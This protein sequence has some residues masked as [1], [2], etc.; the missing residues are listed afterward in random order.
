[1]SSSLS[2]PGPASSRCAPVAPAGARWNDLEKCASHLLRARG[3]LSQRQQAAYAT[4]IVSATARPPGTR[5][6]CSH[7]SRGW[8][9]MTIISARNAGPDDAGGAAQPGGPTPPAQPHS[10]APADREEAAIPGQP[11]VIARYPQAPPPSRPADRAPA[12]ATT[13]TAWRRSCPGWRSDDSYPGRHEK[14]P[15]SRDM[16]AQERLAAGEAAGGGVRSPPSLEPL[17]DG[18]REFPQ[19]GQ[20]QVRY[21]EQ[22]GRRRVTAVGDGHH[23][24]PGRGG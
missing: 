24:H 9:V 8:I 13:S 10:T 12:V 7:A 18:R 21:L 5:C 20:D 3:P 2:G 15:Q 14:R 19:V 11:Q 1:M 23:P 22:L 6:R 17:D 4:S 16:D